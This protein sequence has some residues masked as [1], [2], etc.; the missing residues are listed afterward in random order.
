VRSRSFGSSSEL[1]ITSRARGSLNPAAGPA[2]GSGRS[3]RRGRPRLHQRRHR[4]RRRRAPDVAR[5]RAS[6]TARRTS[7][8]CRSAALSWRGAWSWP[9]LRTRLGPGAHTPSRRRRRDRTTTRRLTRRPS[10]RAAVRLLVSRNRDRIHAG[11]AGGASTSRRRGRAQQPS[12]LRYARVGL[13]EVA[14][15][16]RGCASRRSARSA[17]RVHAVEARRTVAGSDAQ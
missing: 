8:E 3:R 12:R 15:S 11:I 10:A 13:D 7:P 2:H 9:G 5:T 4:L 16:A 6:A 17:R 14:D 1:L